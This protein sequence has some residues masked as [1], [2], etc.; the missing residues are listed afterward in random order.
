MSKKRL[1]KITLLKKKSHINTYKRATYKNIIK[2]IR[3]KTTN[4]SQLKEK[5]IKN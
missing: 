4:S 1:G 3:N 5:L 2:R